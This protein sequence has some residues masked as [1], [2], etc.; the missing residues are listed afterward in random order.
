MTERLYLE[1]PYLARFVAQVREVRD[2]EGRPALVLDRSAFYPEGGGQPGDRG[3]LTPVEP[4]LSQ[5]QVIDTQERDGEVLHLVAEGA[6]PAKA[7]AV[8]ARVDWARRFDHMQQHH[9]QH[10]L[11]AAF[12][13]VHGAPTRSFHLGERSCT[14]DLDCAIGKLDAQAIRRAEAAANESVWRDLPVVARDF[15][16]EE[17]ARLTL[18][19][20]A[21]KGNRVVLVEGVDA[22]PCGGTHPRRTGEVGAIAV[23]RAQR[24]GDGMARIEFVCGGRVVARLAEATEAIA[25]AA[26]ALKAAPA[27]LATAA[28]RIAA[29][30]HARRKAAE[31]L[32]AELALHRARELAAARPEGPVVATFPG[33]AGFA[34]AVATALA[35][36]DRIALVAG[37]ED[38]RAHLVFSRPKGE[39]PALNALLK[40]ALLLLGGKGGGS[41]EHAQGSG[42]PARLTEALAAA[43]ERLR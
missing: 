18:R 23:L 34:R 41:P 19:K 42:D 38:G 9:G 8:E 6:L 43:A 21:V 15:E 36:R 11:S 40:D 37:V 5:L 22:S 1:D 2:L 24:W 7:S 28:R 13:P 12:E 14:I 26:E 17:R 39:G 33:G 4:G 3:V 32:E 29:E 31:A 35:G 16:G 10:L 25:N 30:A 20:E 27:D